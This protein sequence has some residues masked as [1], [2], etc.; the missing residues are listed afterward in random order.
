M[1]KLSFIAIVVSLAATGLSTIVSA[2]SI[3]A[4]PTLHVDTYTG[5]PTHTFSFEGAGFAPNEPV[6]LF[7]GS[8]A[9]GL[10]VAVQ[11]DER[12]NV[13]G[14]NIAIP[15]IPP[16]DYTMTLNGRTSQTPAIVGFNVQGF[17]PWVVLDN[18]YITP[19]AS[20]GFQG[21]DF[22]PGEIVQVYLNTVLTQPV[23]QAPADADGRV[24]A[25][26]AF[27]LPNVTDNNQLIFVGQ[28]SQTRV[29]ATFTAATPRP[30][31]PD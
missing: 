29:T 11:A 10:L 4:P 26:N 9:A 25:Q 8:H 15:L 31:S 18:Y 28:Q 5:K 7:M 19:G 2:Q 1:L 24:A 30:S 14:H 17:H 13:S 23:A 20:V 27:E 16:G 3:S 6:D 22:V 12:G 21:D